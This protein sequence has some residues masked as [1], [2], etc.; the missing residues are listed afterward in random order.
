VPLIPLPYGQVN[1]TKG[2]SEFWN[3]AGP[4]AQ[5]HVAEAQLILSSIAQRANSR[6]ALLALLG[7]LAELLGVAML[8]VAVLLIL[9]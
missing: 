7:G 9:H 1:F 3:E 2:P 6:I 8:A 5:V 4:T